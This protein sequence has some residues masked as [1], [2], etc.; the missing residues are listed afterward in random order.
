M[1]KTPDSRQT[2]IFLA[3][4]IGAVICGFVFLWAAS[5]R[6][7]DFDV[8]A[9]RIVRQSTKI[10][11]RTGK[12]LL[13]DLHENIRRTV[14][15]FDQISQDIKDATV[16]IED[17][18]FYEHRGIKITAFFRAVLVN[19]LSF[20]F[21]QGGS[22]ITQQVVKNALLTQ[23]KTI[24]RKLKEWALSLKLEQE[25][26]KEDILSLY[27]NESPYGGSIYGIQ[28]ASQSFFAKNASEVTLAE[29][30]Y[31]AALPQAPTYYSPYGEHREALDAR[32]NLV[33]ERMLKND[34]ITQEEFDAAKEEVIVFQPRPE[35]GLLAPHFV[36]YVREYLEER[37]GRSAL[38][39][40]GLRVI[41][42]LDYSLQETAEELVYAGALENE[43]KFKAEN[44]GLVAVDP[45]TGEILVMV[46][47]R[48]YFDENIDGNV[49]IATA[50]RQPGS[51][52]KPF[53]YATSFLKGLTPET[54]L[55]DLPTQFST[56]CKPSDTS[57]TDPCYYP[58]NYDGKFRGPISIR[59]ALAQSVNIPAVKALYLAGIG[60]SIKTARNMGIST[61][62]D[63]SR[64]GL[65]LVLG[66]GEVTLLD[67]TSAYGVF[68]N[69]G[70]RNPT[71][72]ILRVERIDGTVLEESRPRPIQVLDK[73]VARQ[74]SDIL[75]DNAA[76]T[77]S[78]GANSALYFPGRDVAAK[79]GTTND[80]RDVWIIGYTPN[81][82]VGM[83]AGNNDNTP[84]DKSVAGFVIAPLWRKFMDVALPT[85]PTE[86]FIQ[87][88]KE[89]VSKPVLAGI[90]Q[91][92]KVVDA[93][94]NSTTVV[95]DVHEILHWA[96][97]DDLDGPVPSKPG[98]DPQYAFW[99]YPV[100]SWALQ[101][102]YTTGRNVTVPISLSETE[103]PDAVADA[104]IRVSGVKDEYDDNDRISLTIRAVADDF[105]YAEIFINEEVVEESVDTGRTSIRLS[106][107]DNLSEE[108]TLSIIAHTE[109]GALQEFKYIFSIQ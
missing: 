39:E 20:E 7:P 82:A 61:L 106:S 76:R 77:P 36:F 8:V 33:L 3:L 1:K 45:K 83:W 27:L 17:E 95:Q 18:E 79:T 54:I 55:F 2:L 32:K 102:G 70:A 22:T 59:S 5:L 47:S 68:A 44:A 29:A 12:V 109:S 89:S 104:I 43:E 13:Y 80:Y 60:D 16:A 4:G 63:A 19:L 103:N 31:L 88:S 66:G 90:W 87:P 14:V 81:L 24:A 57:H 35:K 10:Y 98:S 25:L 108:N 21:S 48:D 73:N 67:I 42:T 94:R 101:N 6:L 26:T 107:V 97:R 28:E 69:D 71:T 51:A 11:D 96:D 105:T 41:T 75:S 84:I 37:Y 58:E 52:F 100:R 50:K 40:D 23:E 78:F 85:R 91:G 62:T 34:Y 9:D 38:E 30:A 86:S 46:G 64:Y 56:A 99:E 72:A 15:P 53:V 92:G 49:N 65:T 74:I 93:D